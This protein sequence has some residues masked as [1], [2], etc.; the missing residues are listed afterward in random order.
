MLKEDNEGFVRFPNINRQITKLD[1]GKSM[2]YII[3]FDV[4]DAMGQKYDLSNI[5]LEM[6]GT[7][8]SDDVN[9]RPVVAK[10]FTIDDIDELIDQQVKDR[11]AHAVRCGAQMRGSIAFANLGQ[12][13]TA[14]VAA[15]DPHAFS[16]SFITVP[17]FSSA[18]LEGDFPCSIK[19]LP[20]I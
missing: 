19:R 12:A 4:K 8:V 13:K 20:T 14:T 17:G 6:P 5:Q 15:D 18:A 3:A 1:C 2:V 16:R 9:R 10:Q 7:F 11:L